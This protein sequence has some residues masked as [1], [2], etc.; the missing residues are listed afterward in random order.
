MKLQDIHTIYF[1]GIG[2]IG[3]SAIARYFR[4]LGCQVAGYDRTETGVTRALEAE[5]IAVYYQADPAHVAGA[6]LMVYT[7]AIG[8]EHPEY[9]A[10]LAAGIP[11]LKRSQILGTISAGSRTL[12]VAGTHGK[13]TTTTML[14]HLLR[15]AGSGC[16]AFLGGISN[17]LQSNFC[18]ADNDLVVAEADEYDR[19][20]LTLHP[21]MAVITAMDPDHLEIYGDAAEMERTFRQFAGQTRRLLVQA[22]LPQTGWADG[23][24]T[25]GLETGDWQARNLQFGHLRTTFDLTG[26]GISLPGLVLHMPG[27]HNVLNMTA[28]LAVAL[29]YGADP[30]RIPAAVA[31]FTGIYR[32]F[33]VLVDS[34]ALTYVDDYAHH[35]AEIAAALLTA[36]D[37]FPDRRLVVVFQPHLYT[38]TRDLCAGFATELS[39]ADAVLLMDIYPAREEPIPGVTSRMILDAMTLADRQLVT[40]QDLL[41]TLTAVIEG[42]TV[43]LTLGAGDIDRESERIALCFRS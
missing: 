4:L 6:D 8:Q 26:P 24:A 30:A 41:T 3:M 42:P 27:R 1:L 36:R 39:R 37:L 15:E 29:H 32:R 23:T 34:P 21:D 31:S 33:E 17:N 19:S 28:A 35:P 13:T 10:A 11:I 22:D 2:G 38:R 18:F 40:R 14:T 25:Y 43:V 16:T 20:F 5:G 7:P 9:Q 12:A